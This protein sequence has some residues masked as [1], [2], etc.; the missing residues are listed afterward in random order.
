MSKAKSKNSMQTGPGLVVIDTN[1]RIHPD[2][3]KTAPIRNGKAKTVNRKQKTEN[4]ISQN[5]KLETENSKLSRGILL[6]GLGHP[7]YGNMAANLASSIRF[8]DKDVKIHLVHTAGSI[9]HFSHKHRALFSSMQECP[10]EYYTKNGKNVYLKAKTCV[11]E[12]SP[13]DQTLFLDADMIWFSDRT[14]K[15]A[16]RILD[17]LQDV[18]LTFQNRGYCDLRD[19]NLKEDFIYWCNI[20]EVKDKYFAD[21]FTEN[22]GRF[23]HLHS[24]FIYFNR[25]EANRK[26]F[27]LAREIFDKPK[28]KAA[29]FDGDIPDELAF[30]IAVALTGCNPHQD[31]FLPI[32]WY[33]TEG[34]FDAGKHVSK[35]YGIS[36][37]GNKLAP[38]ILK[39]YMGLAK[40]YA[41]KMGL[42]HAFSIYPK[43]R[44]SATRKLI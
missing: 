24:E 30:D 37:G 42:P 31:F 38:A 21:G 11:Y 20:K 8:M 28:V 19:E 3:E 44:W 5:W 2:E 26:F 34:P 35:Y 12:L 40:F 17:E 27:A 33:A 18:S 25:S 6:I 16:S 36:I 10:P 7:Q 15:N 9:T 41:S 4:C 1:H 23:Y 39:K 22:N 14:H 29:D 32:H 13:Y 43:K